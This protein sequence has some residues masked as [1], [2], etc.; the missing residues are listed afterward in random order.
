MKNTEKN[1]FN[2]TIG[3]TVLTLARLIGRMFNWNTKPFSFL[4]LR[5]GN[6][7]KKK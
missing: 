6:F 3:N 4:F 2:A 1:D 7:K 5:E